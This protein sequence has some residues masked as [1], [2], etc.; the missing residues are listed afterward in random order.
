MFIS[1]SPRVYTNIFAPT[2]FLLAED[3]RCSF[4]KAESTSTC[5]LPYVVLR[6]N[7]F[8]SVLSLYRNNMES[9]I[10]EYPFRAQLK[11]RSIWVGCHGRCLRYFSKKYIKSYSMAACC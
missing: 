3:E 11:E 9:T 6:D 2:L 7:V 5:S 8:Q 4:M 10:N 1:L